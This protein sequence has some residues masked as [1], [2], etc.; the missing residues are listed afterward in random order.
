MIYPNYSL[1]VFSERLPSPFPRPARGRAEEGAVI[2]PIYPHPSL[3]PARGKGPIGSIF[4]FCLLPF[5][6]CLSTFAASAAEPLT[7]PTR[8][9]AS[10]TVGQQDATS[11]SGPVLQSVM[12]SVERRAAIISGQTVKLG[13]KFGNAQVI[14]ISEG[15]VVLRSGKDLQI[16]KLFPN[17]EK[18]PASSGADASAQSRAQKKVK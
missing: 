16:L 10:L 12:I 7:D 13:D 17:I 18:L 5:A 15:E 9:P 6:F 8:P 3:S 2:L 14:K 4:N 1:E 11:F